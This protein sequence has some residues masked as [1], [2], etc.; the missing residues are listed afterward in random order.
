MPPK[1]GAFLDALGNAVHTALSTDLAGLTVAV[2]GYG[3]I[4]AMAAAIA[5]FAGAAEIFVTDVNPFAI[6]KAEEWK[7]KKKAS[8]VHIFNT[9]DGNGTS[10][11]KEIKRMTRGGVDIVLEISGAEQAINQGLEMIRKGGY[12]AMLGLPKTNEIKINDYKENIIFD[13]VTIQGIIG[14]KMFDTWYRMLGLLKA[15]LD[16]ESVV[17]SEHPSLEEFENGM[18]V[19]D[20]GK[21]LKVVFYPNGKPD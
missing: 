19:F 21:A 14:R 4:G 11:V 15:G 10:V 2:L 17:T 7:E 3:P 6:M 12:L 9:A 8:R 18:A 20:Q 1:V 16:V 5:E 13:G